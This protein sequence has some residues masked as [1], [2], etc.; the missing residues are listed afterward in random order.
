MHQQQYADHITDGFRFRR[1]GNPGMRKP[2]LMQFQK[3][4]IVGYNDPL[5]LF[6][7]CQ[8]LLIRCC[9]HTQIHAAF[10]INASSF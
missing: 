5:S 9:T 7:K 8:M 3:I 10:S 2:L 4:I 6:S 1:K